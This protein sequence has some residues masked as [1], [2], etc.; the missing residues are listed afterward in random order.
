MPPPA[1][2]NPTP[3]NQPL[4]EPAPQSRP[5]APPARPAEAA[6]AAPHPP[7]A[8]AYSLPEVAKHLRVT[9]ETLRSWNRRFGRLLVLDVAGETPR[10][11][12]GDVAVLLTVQKMLEQGLDDEQVNQSLMPRRIE[13]TTA[14]TLAGQPGDEWDPDALA[15]PAAIGDVL[16][17]LA[18]G[19][20]TVLN[21]QAS[22][23]EMV[24]IVVQDNFNLKDENR[25][26]RDRMLELERA[27]AEYQR[28]EETR[29]ERLE[30]RL[31]A[32]EGTLGALQQQMAQMVQLQRAQQQKRRGWW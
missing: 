25:K 17:A 9:P 24:S 21:S 31:R 19:Q 32:L 18:S 14:M 2:H 8:D 23:R 7:A 3:P 29:K 10:Y 15:M 26:L 12:S 16:T 1:A 28:R 20:Q 6:P 27:L 5:A 11:S 4:P 22:M 30:A 13:P